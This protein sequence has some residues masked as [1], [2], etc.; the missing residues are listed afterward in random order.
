MCLHWIIQMQATDHKI[1][2]INCEAF[3]YLE[4]ISEAF[5]GALQKLTIS[6]YSQ[7]IWTEIPTEPQK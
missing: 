3:S 6:K 2:A 5:T 4:G 7:Y 1:C